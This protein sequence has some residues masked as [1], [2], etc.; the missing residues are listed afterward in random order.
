MNPA[1][2][3]AIF[4]PLFMALFSQSQNKKLA[5]IHKMRRKNPKERGQMIELAR[6]FVGRKCYI[7]TINSQLNGTIKEVSESGILVETGKVEEVVN[8]DYVI[9]IREIYGKKNK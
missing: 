4:L 9:R 8:V 2:Y 3:V 6:R 1:I 7:Y 5:S